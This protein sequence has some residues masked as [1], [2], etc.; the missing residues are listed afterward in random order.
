MKKF[1]FLGNWKLKML[2]VIKK[3]VPEGPISTQQNKPGI[4][5]LKKSAYSTK[6]VSYYT[7]RPQSP[8]LVP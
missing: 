3:E 1:S 6:L 4:F 2:P 7:I 5:T 8:L